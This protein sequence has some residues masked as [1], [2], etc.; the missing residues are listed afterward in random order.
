MMAGH[1]LISN[2][3]Q[4]RKINI[5]FFAGCISF[6]VA[7]IWDWFFPINKNL[8]TSSFVLYT[9]G[10]AALILASVS[11]MTD[12]LGR[13]K[14]GKFGMIYGSNAIT[15]Y[16]MADVIQA[17]L[18]ARWGS[19]TDTWTLNSISI[20]GL[21]ALGLVPEMAS[22]LWSICFSLLCFIPIYFLYKKKIF[23][24]I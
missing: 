24:K 17:I 13:K 23:I 2:Q 5:L 4:E 11:F 20:K 1:V 7:N 19:G 22:W 16:V 12:I 6:A 21:L 10:I 8:W 3:T 18:F 9:S 14:W 15:A